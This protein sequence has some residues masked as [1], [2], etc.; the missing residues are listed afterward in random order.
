MQ[1]IK[2]NMRYASAAI[3]AIVAHSI[4]VRRQLIRFHTVETKTVSNQNYPL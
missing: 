4:C 2:H 3:V 1:F